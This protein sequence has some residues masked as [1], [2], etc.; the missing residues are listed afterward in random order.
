MNTIHHTHRKGHT[1]SVIPKYLAGVVGLTREGH[2][3][4]KAL[5]IKHKADIYHSMKVHQVDVD[6]YGYSQYASLV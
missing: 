4:C 5:A 3:T 1:I 2:N 6:Y